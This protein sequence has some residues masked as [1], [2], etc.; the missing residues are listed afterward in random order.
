MNSVKDKAKSIIENAE[1]D[2]KRYL[3]TIYSEAKE[4]GYQDGMKA[5]SLKLKS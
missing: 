3:T 1:S 4:S 5:A 2:A